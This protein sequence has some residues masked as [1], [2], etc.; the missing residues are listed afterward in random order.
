MQGAPATLERPG[1]DT[2]RL[3]SMH[4]QSKA[5]RPIAARH[6]QAMSPKPSTGHVALVKGKRG[7]S[8]YVR[9][10]AGGSSGQQIQKK[11]GPAWTERGRPPAGYFTRRMAETALRTMLADLDRGTSALLKK[12]SGATFADAAA[13]FLRYVIEVRGREESTVADYRGVIDGYLVPRWGQRDVASITADEVETYRDE[14]LAEGRLSARTIVRHLTVLHGIYRRAARVWGLPVNPASAD[15]VERPSV[16]Y[17]GEFTTLDVEQLQALMR[18]ARSEQDAT[19]YLTAAMTGLRQGELRALRWRDLDFGAE[20]IHVRRS[21]TVGSSAKVKTPKS[22]RVRSVPMVPQVAT[23]L[24]RL[25]SRELFTDDDDLV[26]GDARGQIESDTLLRRRYHR[27]LKAAK[28]P[29]FRFHDLRHVFGST[30]VREFPLS[31][32]Q[33]M[34]GHAHVT[35][36]MRYVHHRPG[37]DDAQ[38]LAK[39]FAGHGVS[40]DVSNSADPAELS[41]RQRS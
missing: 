28:L 39:A 36:T 14:L 17:S 5:P 33:A 35:T 20:R 16:R 10:R 40:N 1:A 18:A 19:L 3:V 8:W 32:V 21:A 24:A 11:L 38:R 13:E 25:S 34:L 27:A 37:A 12:E 30:A 31:D 22:G 41:E 29:E 7:S 2:E 26:F 23:V 9:V 15:L 6:H 4:A